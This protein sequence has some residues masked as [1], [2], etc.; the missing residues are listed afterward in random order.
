VNISSINDLSGSS[1]L[2]L[3]ISKLVEGLTYEKV[4]L[5]TS[6]DASLT[7][8]NTGFAKFY[9]KDLNANVVTAYLFDVENFAFCGVKLSGFKNRP[10]ILKFVVQH[11]N[12][13]LSLVVDREYGIKVYDG[14]FDRGR[15]IGK[16][17][18]DEGMV[19]SMASRCFGSKWEFPVEYRVRAFSNIGQGR[20]GAFGKLVELS[21]HQLNGY[22]SL[23]GVVEKDLL[24]VFFVATEFYFRILEAREVYGFLEGVKSLEIISSLNQY[25]Y[26]DSE[27]KAIVIDTV[28]PLAGLGKPKHLYSHLIHNAVQMSADAMNLILANNRMIVGASSNIGGVLLSKY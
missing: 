27:M 5:V 4:A 3:D 7:K 25:D 22:L 17:D 24:G 9:L 15:F 19:K 21:L 20:V 6:A 2:Y 1:D 13:G 11:F 10:V 28:M 18:I 23:S 16:Y 12:G 26:W 14:E 8:A